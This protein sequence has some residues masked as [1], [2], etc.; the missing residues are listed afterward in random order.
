MTPT[1]ITLR[2]L[3]I[4][5]FSTVGAIAVAPAGPAFANCP[6]DAAADI[7]T[8]ESTATVSAPIPSK[9]T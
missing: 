6:P 9:R 2:A 1:A 3:S 8:T 5:A 7:S 4:L